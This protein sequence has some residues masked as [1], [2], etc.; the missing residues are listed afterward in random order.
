MQL[1]ELEKQEQNKPKFIE[2]NRQKKYEIGTK[3]TIQKTNKLVL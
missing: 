1:E 2:S 3:K